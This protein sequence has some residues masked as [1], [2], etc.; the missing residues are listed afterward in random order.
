MNCGDKHC[1]SS[2]FEGARRVEAFKLK[3]NVVRKLNQW[4]PPFAQRHDAVFFNVREKLPVPPHRVS[5]LA[6]I[7]VFEIEMKVYV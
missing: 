1:G 6:G 2:V 5:V 7:R 4:R 3:M